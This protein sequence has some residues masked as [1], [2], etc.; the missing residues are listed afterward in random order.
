MGKLVGGA[1]I[2]SL[3]SAN[4]CFSARFSALRW[5]IS[6]SGVIYHQGYLQDVEDGALLE[7]IS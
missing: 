4:C 5:A 3:A 1:G 7:A 6:S 2:C